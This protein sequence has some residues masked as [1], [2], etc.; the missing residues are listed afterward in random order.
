MITEL[1]KGL[2]ELEKKVL[3]KKLF[4]LYYQLYKLLGNFNFLIDS[5]K[6]NLEKAREELIEFIRTELCENSSKF[7]KTV[8]PDK[9]T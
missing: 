5:Y 2:P 4:D 8:F 7:V 6:I 1:M 3:S 9:E